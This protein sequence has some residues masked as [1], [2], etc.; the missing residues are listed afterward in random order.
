MFV[1]SFTVGE[2][3]FFGGEDFGWEDAKETGRGGW[4]CCGV[5]N[6]D[7]PKQ[8]GKAAGTERVSI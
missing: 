8:P 2:M 5:L 3:V 4:I 7:F 1:R 6:G